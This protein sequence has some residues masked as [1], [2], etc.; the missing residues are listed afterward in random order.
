M[1]SFCWL[2]Q[3]HAC[4]VWCGNQALNNGDVFFVY[5]KM[6]E[7]G[8]NLKKAYNPIGLH[9]HNYEIS[10]CRGHYCAN[11]ILLAFVKCELYKVKANVNMHS[12]SARVDAIGK[13]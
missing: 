12:V 9:F 6:T 7:A 5:L 13:Q 4:Y 1:P 8:D 3:K 11:I 10:S 2:C